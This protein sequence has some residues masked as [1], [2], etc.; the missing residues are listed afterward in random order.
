MLWFLFENY[1]FLVGQSRYK[2]RRP[3]PIHR[4]CGGSQKNQLR[5]DKLMIA[6]E[7]TS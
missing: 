1:S 7:F 5:S 6:E 3:N 2:C 4:R